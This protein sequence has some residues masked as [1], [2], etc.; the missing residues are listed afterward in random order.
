M[1]DNIEKTKEMEQYEEETGKFAI[2][3]GKV[4]E[5]FKRWKK[6]EKIYDK[7]KERVSLYVSDETKAK[8]RKFAKGNDIPTIS[9][10]VRQGVNSFIKRKTVVKRR[11]KKNSDIDDISYL[12]HNLKE[13]LTSIKGYIQLI[14]ET[15][16][17][18]LNEHLIDILEKVLEQTKYLESMIINQL[19]EGTVEEADYD[20]LIVDDHKQT[21]NLLTN[22]FTKKGFKIKGVLTGSQALD[23]LSVKKPKLI[24]LDI[25]LPDLS[26]FAVCKAIK[27]NDATEEIPVYYL[28]AIPE[29]KVKEKI[30]DTRA[31]GY[32]LKPFN[33]SN[34]GFLIDKL[35][36]MQK[37]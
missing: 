5:G 6:G 21:I 1:S 22:F 36:E 14:L 8:W 28:T 33:L 17:D 13:P 9:K 12:S 16:K 15:Y 19:D 18:Q 32:I 7:D 37:R 35:N 24:L 26:G 11:G 30:D 3:R 4:T 23:E 29:S 2:W 10:L 25:I 31:D 34:L 20:I 27:F